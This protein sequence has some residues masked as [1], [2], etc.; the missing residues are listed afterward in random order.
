MG[1]CCMMSW[2]HFPPETREVQFDEKW[3]FVYQKEAKYAPDDQDR[4]DNWDHAAVDA[5]NRHLLRVVPGKRTA[6]KCHQVVEEVKKRKG[7]RTDLLL[8]PDEHAFYKP[9]IKSAYEKEDKKLE[10][11]QTK[12][13]KRKI[14]KD[15]C[16]TTVRKTCKGGRVVQIQLK[17][18]IGTL[19]VLVDWLSRSN[20]SSTINTSFV[21]CHNGTD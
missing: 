10:H 3:G 18:M 8:T 6:D 21:E 13:V 12:K 15:L 7:G 4:G 2:L 16:Y 19:S 1:S 20:V 5:E 9:A 11:S 14:I 17:L